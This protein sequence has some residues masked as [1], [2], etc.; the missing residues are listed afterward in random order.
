ME[1]SQE[2]TEKVERV[3]IK[4]I[5]FFY[6][7]NSVL[8]GQKISDKRFVLDKT[9]LSSFSTV[10]INRQTIKLSIIKIIGMFKTYTYGRFEGCGNKS[11][12]IE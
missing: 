5:S 11:A 3:E 6:I 7:R 1:L 4:T 12:W 8:K 9:Q 2:T 10:E